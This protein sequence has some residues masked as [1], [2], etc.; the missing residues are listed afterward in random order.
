MNMN[1]RGSSRNNDSMIKSGLG[2]VPTCDSRAQEAIRMKDII[3]FNRSNSIIKKF[4]QVEE[5][6]I[7]AI[8]KTCC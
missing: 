6:A 7:H 2:M 4:D 1:S 3:N 5:E 8:R